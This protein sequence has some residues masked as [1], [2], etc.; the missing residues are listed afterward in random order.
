MSFVQYY[1]RKPVPQ[2][3]FEDLQRLISDEVPES[4]TL[5]Y[6]SGGS[7]LAECGQIIS[8]FLNTD[9]GLLIIG[10]PNTESVPDPSG[11]R[12]RICRGQ[13]RPI[14]PVPDKDDAHRKLLS[15]I[16]PLPAG[17]AISVVTAAADGAV[18]LVDVPKS[19][20]PPHQFENS[21][22][23]RLDGETR[24]APQALVEALFLQRR[25]PNLQCT[26]VAENVHPIESRDSDDRFEVTL[27]IEV[28]NNS[29]SIAEFFALDLKVDWAMET[30]N[31]GL[32]VRISQPGDSFLNPVAHTDWKVVYG[33]RLTGW[34]LH[35]YS[36]KV[37]QCSYR[38]RKAAGDEP[39][40]GVQI[41]LQAKDMLLRR[42]D[43]RLDLLRRYRHETL[44]PVHFDAVGEA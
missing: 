23:V 6:K 43:F 41:D 35:A 7:D 31:P 16:L 2:V 11:R 13:F 3:T 9:G 1:L 36:S 30:A 29:R 34:V 4:Q 27:R 10:A 25:G 42:Y 32:S 5:E 28:V 15:R 12:R 17:I 39:Y 40:F 22:F 18:L 21:Y 44:E 38:V 26:V 14:S 37:F 24:K 19:S 20:Y 8:A 33:Y